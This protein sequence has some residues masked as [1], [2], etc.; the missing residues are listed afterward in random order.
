MGVP[1]LFVHCHPGARLLPS[2]V[3]P[4]KLPV[5]RLSGGIEV[6]AVRRP[7][8]VAVRLDLAHRLDHLGDMVGGLAPDGRFEDLEAGEV[9]L[10]RLRV[11]VGDLPRRASLLA[12]P[13]LHLV[14]TSVGI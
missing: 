8:G 4:R 3:K 9:V 5:F 11:E 10:E 7:I 12:R 14:L 2:H 6:D 13:L 1:L